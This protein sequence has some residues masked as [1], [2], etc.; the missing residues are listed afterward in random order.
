[1]LDL[2]DRVAFVAGAGSVAEGWGNGRATAVLLARQGAKVFGTDYSAEA[3]AGTSTVM[4]NEGHSHWTPWQA[5]M[6]SSEEVRL[7]V[8]E[9]LRRYGR[10]DILVNNVGGSTPG[11]PVSLSVEEW[12]GQ[13]DRNLKTAFLG[14]KHVLPVMERQFETE[15]KGGAI[16]NISSIASMSFQVDGRVHVAYAASKA[17][18][19]A[20]SR[21]TAIAYVKKGIRVNSVVVGMMHTPLVAHRLTKQLGSASAEELAAKRDALIPMGRMGDAWDIA[22]AVLFLASD[23]AGYVTATQLVVDGGVTAARPGAAESQV[24]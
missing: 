10:I 12:D 18:L 21:A 13:M 5:D 6:T 3:L 1:M 11:T 7:A 2:N 20:F 14:C 24:R 17:G 8:E 19:E 22:H 9:C 16:V 15:G 4:Q 23:E